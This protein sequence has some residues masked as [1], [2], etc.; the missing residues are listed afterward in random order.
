MS[1]PVYPDV[2]LILTTYLRPRLPAGAYVGRAFPRDYD[3]N[4]PYVVLRRQGGEPYTRFVDRARVG[5]NVWHPSDD[6][7]TDLAQR[8]RALLLAGS[9]ELGLKDWRCSGPAEVVDDTGLKRRYMT[10]EFLIRG[11]AMT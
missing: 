4:R 8:V 1:V 9:G 5:I 6:G 11:A 7:A 10:A 2:E 3:P